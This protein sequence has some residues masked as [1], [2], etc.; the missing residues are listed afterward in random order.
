MVYFILGLLVGAAA[1]IVVALCDGS[2]DAD[3]NQPRPTSQMDEEYEEEE[4]EDWEEY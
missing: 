1:V 2:R 3:D 4:I